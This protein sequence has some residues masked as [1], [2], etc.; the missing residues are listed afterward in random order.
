M[1]QPQQTND[2]YLEELGR[3]FDHFVELV[4]AENKALERR[5]TPLLHE[6]TPKKV[7]AGKVLD[8][9]TRDFHS[10]LKEATEEEMEAFGGLVNRT[11]ALRPLLERNMALLNAAKVTTATRI[12]AGLAA[13]RRSQREKS[14]GYGDDGR[15]AYPERPTPATP[16]RLI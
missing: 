1:K 7:D 9:L 16:V 15:S 5:D 6:L 14:I 2:A 12:E 10:R 3:A 8:A 11:A 4:E 13:W